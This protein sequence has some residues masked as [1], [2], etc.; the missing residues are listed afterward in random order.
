MLTYV[1]TPTNRSGVAA[2]LFTD[3]V[4]S[5]ELMA[6]LGD[7]AFAGLRNEHLARLSRTVEAHGGTVVKNTGDG[8]MAAF[9]SSVEAL[10]AAVGCQEA[11]ATQ[12][13]GNTVS[14]EIRVGLAIG[15]VSFEGEDVFGTPVVEA[16]RLVD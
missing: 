8:L 14:F 16:A 15:E 2:V 10:A 7:A 3:L 4:A 13:A 1:V 5:A 11:A 12:S 6:A 9:G